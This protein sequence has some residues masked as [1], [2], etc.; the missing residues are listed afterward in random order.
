L[1]IGF[2]AGRDYEFG[3]FLADA[4]TAGLAAELLLSAWDVR[5]FTEDSGFL[6]ALLVPTVP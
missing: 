5:P 6:V 3:Q 1:V 4:A 2:G